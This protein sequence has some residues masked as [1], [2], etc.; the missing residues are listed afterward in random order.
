MGVI[1]THRTERLMIIRGSPDEAISVCDLQAEHSAH[2]R[3]ISDTDFL[4]VVKRQANCRKRGLVNGG[5]RESR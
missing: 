4:Q 5:G 3:V 2:S 1:S